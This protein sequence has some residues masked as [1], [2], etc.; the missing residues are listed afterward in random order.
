MC[1]CVCVCVFLFLGGVLNHPISFCLLS[2][3]W[4]VCLCR[5]LSLSLSLTLLLSSNVSISFYQQNMVCMCL[6]FWEVLSPGM[7]DHTHTHT[8]SLSLSSSD[9][10]TIICPLS[11]YLFI[12][13]VFVPPSHSLTIILSSSSFALSQTCNKYEHCNQ[14][15][16]YTH[17]TL[18]TNDLV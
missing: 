13:C 9:S 3:W 14:S 1:V 12:M 11:F 17:L 8:L 15:V 7:F 18:P 2:W 16:S 10:L 5:A 4:W 6:S